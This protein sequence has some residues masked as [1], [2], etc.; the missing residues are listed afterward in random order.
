MNGDSSDGLRTTVLPY[1]IG[2]V[3]ERSERMSAAFHGAIAPT[4][5]TG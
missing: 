3:I 2:A 1:A 5:P 4:T